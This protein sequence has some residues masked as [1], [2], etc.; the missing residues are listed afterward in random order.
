[1]EEKKNI[2]LIFKSLSDLSY[3]AGQSTNVLSQDFVAISKNHIDS[4]E[5]SCEKLMQKSLGFDKLQKDSMGLDVCYRN[6]K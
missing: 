6:L 2:L 3:Y 4:M 5:Y 1:M